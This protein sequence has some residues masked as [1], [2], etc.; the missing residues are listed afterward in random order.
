ML[1]IWARASGRAQNAHFGVTQ[2]DGL[3]NLVAAQ[4]GGCARSDHKSGLQ[5]SVTARMT[6]PSG[7]GWL[8]V[9]VAGQFRGA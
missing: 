7:A 8:A 5:R 1:P 4:I 2:V 3:V 6:L 9:A